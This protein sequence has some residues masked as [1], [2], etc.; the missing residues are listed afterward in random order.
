MSEENL[1][2]A[3]RA[4]GFFVGLGGE[5]ESDRISDRLPDHALEEFLDPEVELIPIAQGILSGNSYKGYEGMR[6]FWADFFS[7]WDE[8]QAEPQE[9]RGAGDQVVVIMRVRARMHE[10][11]VDEVWSQLLTFR[12]GRVVRFQTFSSSDGAFEAAGAEE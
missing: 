4:I 1:D 2:V 7:A 12:Q 9:F 5:M 6:R 8:F 10:L 11:A 3:R